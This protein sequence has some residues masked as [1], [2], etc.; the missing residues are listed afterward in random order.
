MRLTTE[1]SEHM[2]PTLKLIILFSFSTLIISCKKDSNSTSTYY[3]GG[4]YNGSSKT[5]NTTVIATKSNLGQGIY[6][7]T[8]V[9]TNKTEE[10]AITL[11]SDQDNFTAG[12]TYNISA[13]N[14]TT[15]NSLSYVSP[16]GSATPTSIWN[17]T[18]DLG[19]VDQSFT[20]TI[21]EAT[22]TYVKGT[23]SGVLYMNTDSAVVSQ[24]VTTGGFYAK[25]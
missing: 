9:G 18:Y 5:F 13:L 8:I 3:F 4:T 23:F 1:K 25:F 2:K 19:S 14:G 12:T 24:T 22:S 16:I 15:N 21:T 6:N 11:W 20:C 17:T 7:L 10:S